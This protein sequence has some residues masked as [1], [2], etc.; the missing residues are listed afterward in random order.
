MVYENY[1]PFNKIFKLLN[2][3]TWFYHFLAFYVAAN[4]GFFNE[5]REAELNN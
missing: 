5:I 2:H 3:L 4:L 1:F